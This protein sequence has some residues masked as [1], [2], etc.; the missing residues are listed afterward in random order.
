M[1][2]VKFIIDRIISCNLLDMCL[3]NESVNKKKINKSISPHLKGIFLSRCEFDL[4]PQV[5]VNLTR[6]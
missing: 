4:K 6:F 2:I 1:T 3:P 5:S